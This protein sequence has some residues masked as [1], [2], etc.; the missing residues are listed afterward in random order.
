MGA[1]SIRSEEHL[2]PFI[3]SQLAVKLLRKGF[4]T[5]QIA[6]VLNVTQAAVTQYLH[7]KRGAGSGGIPN[8]DELISPLADRLA[9][10]IRTGQGGIRIS[11]LM[12]ISHKIMKM[13]LENAKAEAMPE[14]AEKQEPLYLLR[15]R[16]RLEMTTAQKYLDMADATSDKHTKLLLRMIASD[17]MRNIDAMSQIVSWL[18]NGGEQEFK[19]PPETL[20]E[21]MLSVEN[22]ARD[23]SLGRRINVKHPIGQLLLE[24]IAMDEGKHWRMMAKMLD[25][26]K[27][28]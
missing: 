16:L 2:I 8:I 28:R 23:L 27:Q 1:S 4:R 7:R 22:S 9:R 20:L 11:E 6:A 12:E 21:E 3:R 19:T 13:N 18:E 17:S 14:E 24:W 15:E 25:L 26:S 5:K 10:R